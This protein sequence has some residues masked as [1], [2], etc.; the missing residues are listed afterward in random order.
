MMYDLKFFA[1]W[2]E[3][4]KWTE[5]KSYKDKAPHEYLVKAKIS[6][7]DGK[8]M[9]EFAKY[10][11]EHGYAERFYQTEFVYLNIKGYKYWTMDYP[12]Y[13]TDL[14]NRCPVGNVYGS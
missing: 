3:K 5:A 6:N 12:L 10:I 13:K 9:V 7:E 11:K 8:I 2:V 4:F 1:D 14:V